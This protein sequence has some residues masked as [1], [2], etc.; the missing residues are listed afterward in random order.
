[1]KK[2]ITVKPKRGRPPSGGRDPFVGIRLPKSLVEQIGAWSEEH[3]A[4]T[5]SEAI[6]RLV[7]L[8]LKSKTK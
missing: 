4:K 7:E 8:G 5:R 1:M 6:R 2:S 3:E